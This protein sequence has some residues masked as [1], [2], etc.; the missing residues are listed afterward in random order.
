MGGRPSDPNLQANKRHIIIKTS[1]LIIKTSFPRC[2]TISDSYRKMLVSANM[3]FEKVSSSGL[4]V[5][6]DQLTIY[7]IISFSYWMTLSA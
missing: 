6:T 5:N 4:L 1:Y 3:V 7:N 2:C